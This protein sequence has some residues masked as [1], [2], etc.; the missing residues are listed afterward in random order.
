MANG[1]I[2]ICTDRSALNLAY[3]GFTRDEGK[4]VKITSL[5][6]SDLVGLTVKAPLA[7]YPKVYVLPM[8]TVLATKVSY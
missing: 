8:E 4:L 5:K 6:G 3:Q 1:D 7:Q 2:F